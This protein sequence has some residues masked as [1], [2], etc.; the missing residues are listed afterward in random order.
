MIQV[1][2]TSVVLKAC[3]NG[4]MF[5]LQKKGGSKRHEH[6]TRQLVRDCDSIS[7]VPV[8]T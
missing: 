4:M 2:V 5:P 6:D 8:P 7:T 1:L 3:Y